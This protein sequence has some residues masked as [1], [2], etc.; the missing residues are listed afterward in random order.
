MIDGKNE[1]DNQDD[2]YLHIAEERFN[3]NSDKYLFEFIKMVLFTTKV[4]STETIL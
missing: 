2:N 4:D 3:H 1:K